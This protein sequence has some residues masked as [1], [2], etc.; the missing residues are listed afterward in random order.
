M[1]QRRRC[2]SPLLDTT[3]NHFSSACSQCRNLKPPSDIE[4]LKYKVKF[5]H[6]EIS[7][8]HTVGTD[9]T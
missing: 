8:S 7:G 5:N 1:I 9:D 6:L 2:E 4:P 3:L